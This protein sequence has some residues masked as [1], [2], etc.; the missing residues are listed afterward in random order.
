MS[1]DDTTNDRRHTPLTADDERTAY[2]AALDEAIGGL[3]HRLAVE[4]RAG[5]GEELACLEGDE[6][7]ARITAL[8]DP[9]EVASAAAIAGRDEGPGTSASPF[10]GYSTNL[11]P[12]HVGAAALPDQAA[13]SRSA[14]PTQLAPQP[15]QV[16]ALSETRGYAV[17]GLVTF[18]VGGIVLPV[19]GWLVGCVLVATSGFWRIS[20]K[21]W[22]IIFPPLA[23]LILALLSWLFS[24]VAGGQDSA[25]PLL[26]GPHASILV[27][28]IL[29]APLTAVWLLLRLRSRRIPEDAQG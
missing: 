23:L 12:A 16:R 14:A 21:V 26:P 13:G 8:G 11:P 20:E 18:G 4:L 3:P 22:A 5:V 29:V 2:L 15:A 17:A 28:P 6:L 7:R 24:T 10:A 9:I 1:N 27:T 19:I 25:N